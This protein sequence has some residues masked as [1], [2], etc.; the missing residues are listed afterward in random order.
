MRRRP[1]RTRRRESIMET[2]KHRRLLVAVGM[3]LALGF[4]AAAPAHAYTFGGRAYSAMVTVP[5]GGT[6]FLADTGALIASGG[7]Q[8]TALPSLSVP[9]VL[10]A[11]VPVAAAVRAPYHDGPQGNGS[12]SLADVVVFPRHAPRLPAS[13][14]PALCP[15][16]G[17][18][19]RPS[20][21]VS[22]GHTAARILAAAWGAPRVAAD[23]ARRGLASAEPLPRLRHRRRLVL[24]DAPGLGQGQLR[25]RSRIQEHQP[26]PA[27]Q[28]QLH[29]SQQWYAREGD[30]R[31]HVRG[32]QL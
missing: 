30:Q 32:L 6:T 26:A 8:A 7:A 5:L 23:G 18:D 3:L 22:K 31:R 1:A 15:R 24:A 14:V 13:F 16:S 10:A 9:G 12:T 21:D 28:S 29:R 27:G 11:D 2:T 19:R 20:V 4:V 25:L 17:A